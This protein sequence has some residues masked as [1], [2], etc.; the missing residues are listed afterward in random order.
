M[1]YFY[2]KHIIN[3]YFHSKLPHHRHSLRMQVITYY[4]GS[5]QHK[6][7]SCHGVTS[8]QIVSNPPTPS[9]VGPIYRFWEGRPCGPA[10]W[11]ALLLIKASDVETN[12]GP[13]TTHK[14]I[15]GRKQISIRCTMIEYWVHLILFQVPTHS[16]PTP[17]TPPQPNHIHT[18]KTPLFLQD[19]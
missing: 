14:Q 7:W 10:G 19:W 3:D 13:N 9:N 12:P 11:L 17:P 4:G 2:W 6:R 5:K 16:P 1:I 15:H 8:V 18:S